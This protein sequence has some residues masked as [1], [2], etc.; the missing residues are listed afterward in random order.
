M[1]TISDL[2]THTGY[3]LRMVSNAVS[4]DF[5]RRL[6]D[7]GVTVAEWSFLRALYGVE[8]MAPT[9]LAEKMGMTKGAISKLADRLLEKGL[10]TRVE[11]PEDRRAHNLSLSAAGRDKVP[12]LA[13]HADE[14]DRHYFSPLTPED[15]AALD[16]ILQLLAD[17]RGLR[18][19]PVD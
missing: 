1:K 3:W 9:V 19:T 6:A 10:L 15:H 12:T 14:N 18:A 13:A 17:R 8:A 7:D 2:S 16:R 5:A 4:Q 11:N